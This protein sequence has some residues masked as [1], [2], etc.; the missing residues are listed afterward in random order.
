VIVTFNEALVKQ[1]EYKIKSIGSKIK[2]VTQSQ[3]W[4]FEDKYHVILVDEY[5]DA[6]RSAKMTSDLNGK[7]PA[8]ITHG[9]NEKATFISAHHSDDFLD[10]LKKHVG[11]FH[12]VCEH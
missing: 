10:Q 11:S 1:Y 6:F 12:K 8:I 5:Y 9:K 3:L 7:L 2:V 4:E